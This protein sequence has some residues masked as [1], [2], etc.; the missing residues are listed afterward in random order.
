M[1]YDNVDDRRR[2]Q[3]EYYNKNKHRK[4]RPGRMATRDKEEKKTLVAFRCPVSLLGRMRRIVNEG[5]ALGKFPWKTQ[6][7]CIVAMLIRGM[8]SMAGDPTIDEMLPY[9]RAMQHLE[10]I[11]SHRR[12]AQAAFGHIKTEIAELLAIKAN[13]E[14]V[15][16][17]HAMY[18]SVLDIDENIWRDWLLKELKATFPKLLEQK[19][20]GVKFPKHDRHKKIQQQQQQQKH[21]RRTDR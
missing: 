20:K 12:E 19:P 1:P 6:T 16:Y 21:R 13:D 14:A 3:R 17:F 2:Y 11:A 10:G 18:D 15:K 9:L 8:E 4:K 7:D 5:I